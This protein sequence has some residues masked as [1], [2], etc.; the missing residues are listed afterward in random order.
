VDG[1]GKGPE[2]ELRGR[3]SGH[4]RRI[5]TSDEGGGTRNKEIKREDG[6]E[7]AEER[8]KRHYG[9]TSRNVLSS[10]LDE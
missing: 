8:K 9:R 3:E 2:V 5:S 1:F 10:I 7:V 4:F 6:A